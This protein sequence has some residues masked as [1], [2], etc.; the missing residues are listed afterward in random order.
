MEEFNSGSQLFI[1]FGSYFRDVLFDCSI[2]RQSSKRYFCA[3]K[4]IVDSSAIF[5][6][7]VFLQSALWL[8]SF[9]E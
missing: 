4:Q 8:L 2:R 5:F 3:D 1:V 9:L 7:F 6:T